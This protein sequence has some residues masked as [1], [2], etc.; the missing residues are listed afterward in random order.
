MVTEVA[1]KLQPSA[2]EG[3]GLT[4]GGAMTIHD[5]AVQ[6]SKLHS[7]MGPT[8]GP[9]SDSAE[10]LHHHNLLTMHQSLHHQAMHGSMLPRS[11]FM[12]TDIL[13]N[14][15]NNNSTSDNNNGMR[16]SPC[17]SPASVSS[18]GPR[19]LSL[20]ARDADADLSDDHEESGTDSG[21]PGETSSVC[22]NGQYSMHTP[23]T[24]CPTRYTDGLIR[25][26]SEIVF[27]LCCSHSTLMRQTETEDDDRVMT[28]SPVRCRSTL[29][30]SRSSSPVMRSADPF[31]T[32]SVSCGRA[33]PSRAEPGMA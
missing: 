25:G 30:S 16:R 8:M 9:G 17:S 26:P 32:S 13:A 5:L 29:P 23:C 10:A 18:D 22:S 12:I 28:M 6:S 11:R 2:L 15:N 20:H 4:T 19:D 7:A 3:A 27:S 21:L 33:V 24:R 31:V 14:N 1:S